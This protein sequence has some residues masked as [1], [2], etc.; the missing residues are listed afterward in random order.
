MGTSTPFDGGR[1]GDPLLPSFLKDPLAPDVPAVPDAVP[2]SPEPDGETEPN[3]DQDQAQPPNEDGDPSQAAEAPTTSNFTGGRRNFTNFAKSGGDDRRALGRA[4]RAY[5]RSVGGG[6]KNAAR[7]MASERSA[8]GAIAR[9]MGAAGAA[10][11]GIREFVRTIN[12]SAL[13]DRP[14]AEIYAALVDYVCPPDGAMD[15]AYAR[16][17]Y[18]EAVA[19]LTASGKDLEHPSEAVQREFMTSFITNAVCH[20]ITIAIRG[21]SVCMPKDVETARALDVALNDFIRGSVSDTLAAEG[22]VFQAD[23]F[24]ARID[25]VYERV[26]EFIDDAAGIAAGDKR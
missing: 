23:A 14:V 15:D 1:N 3:S 13:A 26:I 6:A 12:L 25:G 5:V 17:A 8:A 7:R 18:L 9:F 11:G 4:V 20:R 22:A 21:G 19:E 2:P 16:E 24:Q 10:A